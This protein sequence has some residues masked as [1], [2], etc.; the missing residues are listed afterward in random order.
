MPS[1]VGSE[2][3]GDPRVLNTLNK[4]LFVLQLDEFSEDSIRGVVR[5]ILETDGILDS[6]GM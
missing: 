3:L 5:E 1:R 6:L 2:Y 4:T